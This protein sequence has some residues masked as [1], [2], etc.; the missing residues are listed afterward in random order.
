MLRDIGGGQWGG[1]DVR[2]SDVVGELSRDMVQLGHYP[3]GEATRGYNQWAY[4]APYKTQVDW[5]IPIAP[6]CV[7]R[8]LFPFPR[9]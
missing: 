4:Q 7:L 3:L 9:N 8:E 1:N 5:R 2:V 6:P